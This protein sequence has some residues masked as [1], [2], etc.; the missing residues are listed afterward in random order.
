M[1]DLR[2]DIQGDKVV[3]NGLKHM[4]KHLPR[5]AGRGLG[6]IARGIHAGAHKNLSGPGA[7]DS[8]I[9]PGGYPVPVRTG[10]LRSLLD[11]LNPGESK[12]SEGIR[13]ETGPNEAMVFDSAAYA[14]TIHEGKGS[15]E[16]F[17]P[18]PYITDAAEAFFGAGK[19][20]KILD[21]EISREMRKG[22]L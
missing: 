12:T 9:P 21:E 17:G 11:W 14:F 8:N 19:P 1:L 18:R 13:F 5:A 10:H 22:G 16:K 6:R 15:S 7:K 4:E 20:E 2:V 3:L